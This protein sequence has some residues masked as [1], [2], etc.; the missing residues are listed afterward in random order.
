MGGPPALVPKLP[1]RVLM[2]AARVP[3]LAPGDSRLEWT[4]GKVPRELL[5]E[6]ERGRPSATSSEACLNWCVLRYRVPQAL[7]RMGLPTGPRRHCGDSAHPGLFNQHVCS[8]RIAWGAS[9]A[10]MHGSLDGQP[11]ATSGSK[12]IQARFHALHP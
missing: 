10:D 7:H 3:R 9:T 5:M 11:Q 8:K 6:Q 1:D 4:A 2:L 12:E